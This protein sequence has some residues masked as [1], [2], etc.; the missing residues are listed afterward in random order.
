MPG[1]PF[2][3]VI[4]LINVL[5]LIWIGAGVAGVSDN[6]SDKTGDLRQACEAGTALG[7][8]I[9]V[10]LDAQQCLTRSVPT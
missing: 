2:T 5:F 8:T 4:V 3:W 10:G 9:G 6:C 1:R 7:A